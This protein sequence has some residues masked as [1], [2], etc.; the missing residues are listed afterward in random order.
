HEN[1]GIIEFPVFYSSAEEANYLFVIEKISE[2]L[3]MY[4][5]SLYMLDDY[6]DFPLFSQPI[7]T[8][9]NIEGG[10]GFIG[11]SVIIPVYYYHQQ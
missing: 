11:T 6:Y 3:F 7:Q 8:Y 5:H 10:L 4:E 1:E 2:D 9:M